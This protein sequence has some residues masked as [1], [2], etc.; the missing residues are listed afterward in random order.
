VPKRRAARIVAFQML[1]AM[2]YT[3][4]TL[5]EAAPLYA[6]LEPNRRKS[7]PP[8]ALELAKVALER[9]ADFDARIAETLEHWRP[10][11]LAVTDRILLRLACAELFDFP[12]IPPRVTLDEYIEL[13]REFGDEES[14]RFVNGVLDSIVKRS[15]IPLDPPEAAPAESQSPEA[16]PGEPSPAPPGEEL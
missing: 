3:G 7:L 11:R 9:Q 12:A 2:S 5:E 16:D 15:G 14:W 4:Q 10:E 1:Y 6:T 13:A 8:F